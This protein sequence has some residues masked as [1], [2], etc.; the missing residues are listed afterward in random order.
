MQPWISL[1]RRELDD[2]R[3]EGRERHRHP[4]RLLEKVLATFSPGGG[5]VLDPFAGLATTGVVAERMGRR[6]ITIELLSERVAHIRRRVGP[7]SAF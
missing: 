3:P 7:Q 2:E 6:A 5:L 4:E 1:T